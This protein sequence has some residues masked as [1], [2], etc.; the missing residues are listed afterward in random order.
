[1]VANEILTFLL[2][3]IEG[4]RELCL[5]LFHVVIDFLL[6]T[7]EFVKN[8]LNNFVYNENLYNFGVFS[9]HQ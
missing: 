4:L 6:H 8:L 1:M 3:K 2:H 5:V 9:Y 7:S